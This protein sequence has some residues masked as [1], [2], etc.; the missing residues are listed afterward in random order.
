ME[1]LSLLSPSEDVALSPCRG[2]LVRLSCPSSTSATPSTA[3]LDGHHP[4]SHRGPSPEPTRA[5]SQGQTDADL[6]NSTVASSDVPSYSTIFQMTKD[7]IVPASVLDFLSTHHGAFSRHS[8][9]SPATMLSEFRVSSPFLPVTEADENDDDYPCYDTDNDVDHVQQP[10]QQQQ[11]QP[12]VDVPAPTL[13]A[14]HPGHIGDAGYTTPTAST[15][16][17]SADGIDHPPSPPP[18]PAPPASCDPHRLSPHHILKEICHL[19]ASAT[20]SVALDRAWYDAWTPETFV[21]QCLRVDVAS[22]RASSDSSTLAMPAVSSVVAVTHAMVWFASLAIWG[23]KLDFGLRLLSQARQAREQFLTQGN[24]DHD[25]SQSL[26]YRQDSLFLTR[27][28]ASILK[29]QGK[30]LEE[31][32]LLL[33]VYHRQVATLGREHPDCIETGLELA[34]LYHSSSRSDDAV[35]MLTSVLSCVNWATVS[36]VIQCPA[37]C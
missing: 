37:L 35:H 3:G 30:V 32:Q 12:G 20:Y 11:Q 9:R 29:F 24:H 4:H 31:E 6:H 26:L 15:S 34:S 5:H 28:M 21:S 33:Q 13:F 22:G 25:I 2:N 17:P 10:H 27:K 14:S 7:G 16:S 23:G 8:M 19:V 36:I 1:T 18:P